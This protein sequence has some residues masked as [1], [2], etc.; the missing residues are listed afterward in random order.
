MIQFYAPD[1]EISKQLP[2]ADSQHCVRV[3]RMKEGDSVVVVD[4]K[5]YRYNCRIVDAHPKHVYLS[6][7]EKEFIPNHWKG[8]ITLG[9][10]PTKNMDRME[11]LAEKTTEMGINSIVPL[12]CRH[13][14]RKE[15]KSDR[16]RKIVISAMKQSLKTILPEVENMTTIS[17][18]IRNSG[19]G[20]KYIAYCDRA[21]ERRDFASICQSDSDVTILIGPEGDFSPEEVEMAI[22]AGF[23]P[24][25][26]GESRLRT[27]TAGLFAVATIHAVNQLNK[28]DKKLL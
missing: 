18:F 4:G 28:T 22:N 23:V 11:W 25:S 2:E 24:V 3:L 15:I 17:D 13:S 26:L 16:L 10:A 14:E 9:I 19:S 8:K 27:E 6:I 21:T 5:G 7:Y 12:L 1:I 20:Q